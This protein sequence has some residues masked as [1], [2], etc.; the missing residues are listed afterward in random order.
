MSLAFIVTRFFLVR[1]FINE[2]KMNKA[3]RK[4]YRQIIG[5]LKPEYS[6]EMY[7][8]GCLPYTNKDNTRLGTV[9]QN[10]NYLAFGIIRNYLMSH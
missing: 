10:L 8:L 4:L 6:I 3:R 5:Y 9:Y 7:L 2:R 1:F